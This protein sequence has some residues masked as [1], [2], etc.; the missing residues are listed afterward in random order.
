MFKSYNRVFLIVI[1]VIFPY[2]KG[3]LIKAAFLY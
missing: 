1:H 2:K 3:S